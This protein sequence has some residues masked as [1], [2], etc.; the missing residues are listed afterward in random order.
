MN[1]FQHLWDRPSWLVLLLLPVLH[2]G[3]IQLSFFCGKT[4]ENEVIVWMPNAVLLAALLRFR[5]ERGATM[6]A[7]TVATNI[8]GNL[9]TAPWTEALLLSIV[10]VVEVGLT[11]LLMRP[12]ASSACAP[13]SALSSP[14]R[15]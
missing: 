9:P 8:A 10:N 11:F 7:L 4:A 14:A 13:S 12:R 2:Y 15:C 6:V 5:G 3:A 1:R